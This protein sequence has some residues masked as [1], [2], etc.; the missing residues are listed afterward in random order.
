M[1]E[2]VAERQMVNA[3]VVRIPNG[4]HVTSE[5]R[6]AF[7]DWRDDVVGVGVATTLGAQPYA[8]G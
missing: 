2:S 5:R 1:Q 8:D 3:E 7:Q 4:S 6:P